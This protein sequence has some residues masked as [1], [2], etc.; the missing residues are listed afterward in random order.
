MIK[1]DETT[2]AI[3]NQTSDG[4]KSLRKF[5]GELG[6]KQDTISKCGYRTLRYHPHCRVDKRL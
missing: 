6:I 1:L 5:T 4:R 3:I 2:I